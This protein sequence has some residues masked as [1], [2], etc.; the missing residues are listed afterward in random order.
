LRYGGNTTCLHFR[1]CSGQELILDGGSGIRLLGQK[2]MQR[3]FAQ[4][5]GEAYILVGHTHWDHIMGFPF[6]V[7]FYQ[8]GNRFVVASAGQSG[9]HIRDIL[10]WQQVG[11]HFP[12]PFERLQAQREYLNFKPGEALPL[13]EFRVETVQLNHPGITVGYRVEADGG[14]VAVYTDNARVRRVRL[15]DGMGGPEPDAGFA[16]EF[17]ER[18]AQCARRADVLVYD[19]H[20]LEHEMVGRYH[21]GH[22]TVEDALEIAHLAGVGQ[23]VLFHH[24]P[25]HSDTVVDEKLALARDLS[26][27]ESFTVEAAA[28]GCRLEVGR[29][30]QVLK[31]P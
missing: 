4:G 22:S 8:Q 29:I 15:G 23:L 5:E 11:L 14:A 7:P 31:G 13:G 24:A 6:F 26:R 3:E 17:L 2:M 16:I 18:L 9:I 21:F 27:G 28:E 20:Y 10:S 30:G 1:T 12:V 25:E 19:T